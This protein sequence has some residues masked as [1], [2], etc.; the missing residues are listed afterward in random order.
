LSHVIGFTE[1]VVDK[2]C[3]DLNETQSEYLQDVLQSGRHLLSLISEILD[4]SK[5]EAGK[6][7]LT[8]AE[9]TVKPLL[10]SSLIMVKE[11][12]LKR[13]LHLSQALDSCPEIILADEGRLKQILYNLLSNA[14][15]FTPDGGFVHVA[16]RALHKTGS[17]KEIEFS[18]TDSG[19]ESS[20][21]IRP[22]FLT[23]LSRWKI[24]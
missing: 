18:V 24:P 7:D 11:K 20:L 9:V 10:Q 15:K 5:I 14:V 23:P 17:E 16:V 8:L 19:W 1:M 12:A 3:G 13:R 4:L 21:K 6:M 2:Q 22:A